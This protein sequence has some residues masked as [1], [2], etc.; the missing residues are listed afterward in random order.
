MDL[1]LACDKLSS[2]MQTIRL[3]SYKNGY[4]IDSIVEIKSKVNKH[5]KNLPLLSVPML[6]AL[7]FLIDIVI[8]C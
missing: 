5:V 6:N 8:I 7:E 3:Q 4:D 2:L 1:I